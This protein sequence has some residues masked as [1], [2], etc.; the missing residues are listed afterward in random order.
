MDEELVGLLPEEVSRRGFIAGSLAA[1]F[2]LAVQPV[3]AQTVITTDAEGLEAGDVKIPVRDGEMPGYRAMPARGKDFPV[4]L[5]VQE[6]FGVHEHIKDV[7]RRFA[8]LG[9]L[10][11]APSL[12]YRQGD[13]TQL[14]MEDV[15]K[16]VARVPDE[17]VMSDLDST[18]AYARATGK[19]DGKRVGITGFC[20][21]GRIV[22]LYA[23][24]SKEVDAGVAWYGRLVARTD[25]PANP[26]TPKQPVDVVD[27]M[28]APV[29]G[30][31][32]G[33]DQGIPLES[34]ER[35]RAALKNSKSKAARASEIVVY[36]EAGHGFHADYRP[37]YNKE[38]A[39]DGWRR[40]QA[41]F[42]KHG[43]K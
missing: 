28:N 14:K 20:W 9:Y 40:L 10:A 32:G 11:V 37:S 29:L 36:P 30:L 6:I 5:V 7:C 33:K 43:A 25:Q 3:A 23:A 8:R 22:W 2:A 16:V 38:A 41:W 4:A 15:M 18:V 13:T 31:Y 35:M 34:V 42:K 27:Q 39:T 17:Q 24:H 21:G 19:S 1:G 26:L 12:Y